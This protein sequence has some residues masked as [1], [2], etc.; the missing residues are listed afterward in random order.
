MPR[1]RCCAQARD[2]GYA[3][4]AVL[5]QLEAAPLLRRLDLASDKVISVRG[6]LAPRIDVASGAG[7]TRH[8]ALG[9][10][11]LPHAVTLHIFSCVPA[12]ARARAALVCRAWHVTVSDPQLW[13]VLDMSRMAYRNGFRWQ[14]VSD[15]MLRGAAAL[16]RGGLTALCLDECNLLTN[17]ARLEV[18]RANAGSLRELSCV[19]VVAISGAHVLELMGAAPQLVAFK[20][21][22]ENSSVAEATRMLRYEAPFGVLQLRRLCAQGPDIN[23]EEALLE[24]AEVLAFCSA[25]S[26]HAFLQELEIK[27]TPL[28]TPAVIKG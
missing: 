14:P 2:L 7:S 9:F 27:E 20:V 19:A 23:E 4:A 22:M 1:P 11:D 15:A 17:E 25:V 16:A 8:G 5:A 3:S 6:T 21:E 13:T 12:D 28:S 10:A 18:V 24:E 26:A